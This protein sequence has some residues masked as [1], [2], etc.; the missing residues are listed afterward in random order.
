VETL[1]RSA[2]ESVKSKRAAILPVTAE[3]KSE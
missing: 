2:N 3:P 1:P